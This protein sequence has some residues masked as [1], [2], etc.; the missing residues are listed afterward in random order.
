MRACVCVWVWF[1]M[2]NSTA[3]KLNYNEIQFGEKHSD[4]KDKAVETC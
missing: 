1:A 2:Q 4:G 3:Q